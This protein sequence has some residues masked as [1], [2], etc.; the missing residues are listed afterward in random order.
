MSDSAQRAPW[1]KRL[2]IPT[3]EGYD[4]ERDSGNLD[5]AP[6]P[7]LNNYILLYTNAIIELAEPAVKASENLQAAKQGLSDA[8]L[9]FERFRRDTLQ[10]QKIPTAYAKTNFLIDTYLTQVC[11]ESDRLEEYERLEANVVQAEQAV[12]HWKQKVSML[13][14]LVRKLEAACQ[15][16]QTHLSYVKAEQRLSG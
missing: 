11:H 1:F 5:Y 16:I 3:Y 8:Q 4:L 6:P 7:L 15:N 9:A 12:E 2:A 13:S 10:N 14:E